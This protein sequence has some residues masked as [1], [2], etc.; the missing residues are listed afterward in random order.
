MKVLLKRDFIIP[1]HPRFQG[2]ADPVEIPD[3]ITLPA[4][5]VVIDE[6]KPAKRSRKMKEDEE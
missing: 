6:E 3:G 5:A 1:D 2:G 4:D